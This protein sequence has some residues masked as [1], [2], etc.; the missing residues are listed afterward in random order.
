MIRF[1]NKLAIFLL[2]AMIISAIYTIMTT[3]TK[4]EEIWWLYVAASLWG[5]IRMD[6]NGK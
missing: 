2:G 4:K 6:D 3:V 5:F 1:L